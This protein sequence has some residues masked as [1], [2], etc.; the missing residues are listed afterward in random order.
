MSPRPD[1]GESRRVSLTVIVWNRFPKVLTSTFL[2]AGEIKLEMPSISVEGEVSAL[3]ADP[4]IVETLEQCVI[5]W[6]GQISVAVEGQL[7]KTPQVPRAALGEPGTGH[8]PPCGRA[9]SGVPAG[10][11]F[12]YCSG[13]SLEDGVN[14]P[15]VLVGS[16][17]SARP[18]CLLGW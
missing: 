4:E 10:S 16:L 9:A 13:T 14:V 3:A 12:S 15:T 6:L 1:C 17:T 2:L 11:L 8:A 18:G 7:R 5:N